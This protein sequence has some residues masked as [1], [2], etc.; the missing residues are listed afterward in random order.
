MDWTS[1]V[2]GGIFGLLLGLV[3]PFGIA[4]LFKQLRKD[5]A[6]IKTILKEKSGKEK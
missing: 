3:L 5:I 4:P 1:F 6:R 2:M